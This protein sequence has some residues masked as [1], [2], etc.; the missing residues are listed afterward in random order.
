MSNST[1][2]RVGNLAFDARALANMAGTDS[3]PASDDSPGA[4]WLRRVASAYDRE[5]FTEDYDVND[6]AFE[7]AA[8]AS[9]SLSDTETWG[10]VTDLKLYAVAKSG[11]FEEGLYAEQFSYTDPHTFRQ[12]Y[13]SAI[14]TDRL[15]DA[16]RWW[17]H[18][19][20]E[21]LIYEILAEDLA[22]AEK[23]EA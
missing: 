1:L 21:R 7:L 4:V 5:A 8:S 17:L 11:G 16:L 18:E 3:S 19:T 12:G 20:A 22:E 10:I 6:A 14:R 23:E 13:A 9:G 15:G 2:V